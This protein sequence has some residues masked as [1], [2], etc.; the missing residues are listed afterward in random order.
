M[1]KYRTIIIFALAIV[2]VVGGFLH[3]TADKDDEY[4][5]DA[6]LD[7]HVMALTGRETVKYTNTADVPLKEIYF[8][9]YPNAFK[10]QSIAP[11][12]K[13]E[14]G[15][16]YPDGF[17]PGYMDILGV[18]VRNKETR[19]DIDGINMKVSLPGEL[20]PGRSTS[21]T[22]NFMVKLPPS[23]GRFGYGKNTIRLANWY[24][25]VSMYGK[26]GWNKDPYYATGDPFYSE[27]AKYTVRLTAPSEY[28]V[29]STGT[30]KTEEN[31]T[32]KMWYINADK[33]RDMAV[34]LSDKFKVKSTSVGGT[35]VNSYYFGDDKIGERSL[36]YAADALEY[37][38]RTFGRYP[39]PEYD[40]VEADFYIGG[41]EYPQ[42]SMIDRT[43][44][45]KNNIFVLEQIIAHETAHQWWYG[46]VGNNEVKEPWL[47]EALTEYSTMQYFREFYGSELSNRFWKAYEQFADKYADSKRK[48]TDPVNKFTN[49]TEYSAI[50]YEKG[51]LGFK[52]IEDAVGRDNF[53]KGLKMYYKQNMYKNVSAD[54]LIEAISKATGKD[55]KAH[56]KK[57]APRS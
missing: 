43:I 16:A 33:V 25:I 45:S 50:V 6:Q 2:L 14:M 10:A 53:I 39:Y 35:K 48:V 51:A 18:K 29:A 42:L 32:N 55:M 8:H 57:A 22:I 17:S 41:M 21:I 23:D 19:F 31:K 24:P 11:F 12:P 34:V 56:F 5:I 9:L 37:Y 28:S 7:T 3:V 52:K 15:L 54:D 44:Y 30:A 46:V 47:D 1:R 13:D 49:D 4:I 36:K 26:D 27:T 40:V 38:S 20:M